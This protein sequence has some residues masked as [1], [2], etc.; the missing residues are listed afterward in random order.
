MPCPSPS[1]RTFNRPIDQQTN[2]SSPGSNQTACLGNTLTI[3]S[4]GAGHHSSLPACYVWLFCYLFVCLFIY[5]RWLRRE[6]VSSSSLLSC[7]LHWAEKRK[8]WE[9]MVGV[10]CWWLAGMNA[11][12]G[13]IACGLK[14]RGE[15]RKAVHAVDAKASWG[16]LCLLGKVEEKL[17]QVAVGKWE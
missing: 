16:K 2:S 4:W 12:V 10:S 1:E 7:C 6:W 3:T 17:R 9:L 11:E 15:L 13:M 14:V 8:G 5:F